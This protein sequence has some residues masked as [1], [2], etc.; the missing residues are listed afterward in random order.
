MLHH[1]SC[2][3]EACLETSGTMY[4]TEKPAAFKLRGCQKAAFGQPHSEVVPGFRICVDTGYY[5]DAQTVYNNGLIYC[6]DSA[7]GE[8]EFWISLG[9]WAPGVVG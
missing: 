5:L 4:T 8:S 7:S 6:D 3:V 2:I 9:F 1:G